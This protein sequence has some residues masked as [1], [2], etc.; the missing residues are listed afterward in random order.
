MKVKDVMIPLYDYLRPD[1]TIRDAV[2][3]IRVAK[4]S[5]E[6]VGVKGA[7]VLD[8]KG[9]LVGMVTIRDILRAAYPPYFSL[10]CMGQFTWENMFTDMAK[11]I[12]NKLVKDIMSTDI[13]TVREETT[14][15]ACLDLMLKKG[16]RR[17]PVLDHEGKVLGMVYEREI[18]CAFVHAMLG[19]ITCID[20]SS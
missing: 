7:P 4:R 10:A 12:T 2:N 8:E 9:R 18:F 20:S 1:D 14:L 3:I 16:I 13:A 15:M 6:R 5:E 17:L 11:K 19:D